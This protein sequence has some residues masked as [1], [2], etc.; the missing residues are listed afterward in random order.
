MR[1]RQILKF[2][3]FGESGRSSSLEPTYLMEATDKICI[4]ILQS[5]NLNAMREWLIP[6]LGDQFRRLNLESPRRS[7]LN[8]DPHRLSNTEAEDGRSHPD[9]LQYTRVF[10][11]DQSCISQPRSLCHIFPGRQM[12]SRGKLGL[13]APSLALLHSSSSSRLVAF[14]NALKRPARLDKS[15]RRLRSQGRGFVCLTAYRKPEQYLI[16][17][18]NKFDVDDDL[19]GLLDICSNEE[20]EEIHK[21]LYGKLRSGSRTPTLFLFEMKALPLNFPH[22]H[23]QATAAR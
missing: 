10:F 5:D 7:N 8:F 23:L 3:L 11:V 2:E 1:A 16:P 4:S 20:L 17:P 19:W 22:P 13:S 6:D 18:D 21:I 15:C 12:Q 14:N 9:S